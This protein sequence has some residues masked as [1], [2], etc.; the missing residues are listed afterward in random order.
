L[1]SVLDKGGWLMPYPGKET[2][3]H[4]TGAGWATGPVWTGVEKFVPPG[5][6]PQTV[7]AHS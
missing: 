5:F 1:A 7:S 6:N 4:C 2:Q 3:Y